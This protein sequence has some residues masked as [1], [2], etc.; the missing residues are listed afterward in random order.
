MITDVREWTEYFSKLYQPD[1]SS[2]ITVL[3][4]DL[5][6]TRARLFPEPTNFDV[7]RA[8]HLNVPFSNGEIDFALENA[9]NGKSAGVDGLQMEFL[10]HAVIINEGIP[11]NILSEHITALFNRILIE[12]YPVDW[13]TCAL[14]PVPKP[15]GSLA[16]KDDYRGIAIGGALSKLYSTVLLTRLDKWAEKNDLRAAGQAG[17][18]HSRGTPDNAFILNHIIEKYK[19]YSKPV[20]AAFID[21]RKAYDCIDRDILWQSLRSLGLHGHILESLI[22]IYKDVNIR[23]RVGGKL[24]DVFSSFLGVKQGDPLSPLL[25]GLFIDRF[26]KFINDQL[27]D[28]GVKLSNML[29]RVLFYADDLVIL[30][31]SPADLQLMLDCLSQFCKLNSMTV[32]IKKSE[33]V[34]FNRSEYSGEANLN[35]DGLPLAIKPMFIYLGMMYE[36]EGGMQRAGA[37]SIAKGRGA[38]YA[39]SRR[40]NEADIHNVY[41]KCHLFDSLVK[42]ILYYG[43]EVWAPYLFSKGRAVTSNIFSRDLENIHKG[44]L[45]Q[46]TGVR[47]STPDIVLLT[48]LKREPLIFGVL[49][50]TINFWNKSIARPDHDLLKIAIL[51]SCCMARSGMRNCWAAHM[52]RRLRNFG[53]NILTVTNIKIPMQT[54]KQLC[55]EQ[56]FGK[57]IPPCCFSA[58]NVVRSQPDGDRSGFK[59]LVY[60]NWFYSPLQNIQDTFWYNLNSYKQISTISRFRMGSHHLNIETDRYGRGYLPRSARLCKCCNSGEREDELHFLTCPLYQDLRRDFNFNFSDLDL[61]GEDDNMRC[62]VNGLAWSEPRLF[63]NRFACFL[64]KCLSARDDCLSLLDS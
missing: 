57:T 21:F 63:W 27:P 29:I 7:E 23:I 43:C 54:I 53:I 28:I 32:N 33:A 13:S 30:A 16:D 49:Q 9:Y 41:I 19:G 4:N 25:F 10:K 56:Y 2:P 14:A 62:I 17:F 24:G 39:L 47:K 61:F 1:K 48:E 44:F 26:E 38:L 51:E 3:D 60:H 55:T 58:G 5:I 37:R 45:R 18:R 31:E 40:C 36:E 15:K 34:I 64:E 20:F 35:F 6:S 52:D 42:P 11:Y 50:Q 8:A 22:S 59:S 12:G 46:S